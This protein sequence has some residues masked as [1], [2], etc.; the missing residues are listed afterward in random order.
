MEQSWGNIILYSLYSFLNR[1][2]LGKFTNLICL[3]ANP[4][5]LKT[6]GCLRMLW[7]HFMR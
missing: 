1:I 5:L 7:F 2:V 3:D 4:K 6:V